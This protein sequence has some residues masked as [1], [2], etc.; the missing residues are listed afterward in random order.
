MALDAGGRRLRSRIAA[1]SSWAN[2]PNPTA[3]T[4][5]ARAGFMARFEREVD[6]DGSLPAEQRARR[7][8]AARRAYFAR[9]AY[10]SSIARSGRKLRFTVKP[11]ELPDSE[12]A[13]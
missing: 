11:I 9:L 3:R 13:A 7:A 4:A 2:T 6:P 12:D 8:E 1:Y 10:A 5:P